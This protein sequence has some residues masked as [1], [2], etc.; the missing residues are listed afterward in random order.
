MTKVLLTA[1]VLIVSQ[2]AFSSEI[3]SLLLRARVSCGN[4]SYS[5]AI[6]MYELY[7]KKSKVENLK[8]V[9][10]EMANCYFFQNKKTTAIKYI[11]EAISKYGFTEEDFIYNS[12]LNENL[13]SFALSVVY[14]DYFELRKKYLASI[15]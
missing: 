10:I 6:K 1:M 3:D 8:N 2:I 12:V 4:E 7:I 5:E 11:K 9:Y 14:D 15:N 13:S